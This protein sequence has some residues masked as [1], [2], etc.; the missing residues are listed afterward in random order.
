MFLIG[1]IL[2]NVTTHWDITNESDYWFMDQNMEN[3]DFHSLFT[4]TSQPWPLLK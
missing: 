2:R 1:N 3:I 4:V